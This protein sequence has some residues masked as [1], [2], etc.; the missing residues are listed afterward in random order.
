MTTLTGSA[1]LALAHQS[2][3]LTREEAWAA[4]HVDEDYQI[5]L[6]GDDYEASVRRTLRRAD[7]DAAMPLAGGVA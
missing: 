3:R 5:A 2:G 6:W 7:F 4:A 1:L